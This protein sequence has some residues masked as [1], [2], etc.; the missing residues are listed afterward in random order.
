MSNIMFFILHEVGS[1][2]TSLQ[3]AIDL[4]TRGHM[5]SYVGLADSED[6][7]R[8]NGF[9]FTALFEQHFPKTSIPIL[10]KQ[11]TLLS[12]LSRLRSLRRTFATFNGF[13]DHLVAGGDGEFFAI[14]RRQR[15]D[16]ILFTGVPFVEWAV[17]MACAQ[18]IK[19]LYLRPTLSL[20]EGTGLPP[21]T[22]AVIPRQAKSLWQAISI[23]LAWRIYEF[24]NAVYFMGFSGL[25]RKLAAKYR[26]KDYRHETIYAKDF[27]VTLPEIIPFHPDFDFVAPRLPDQHYIGASICLERREVAFPW[28]RLEAERPL[29]YCALG[30][31]LW[32]SKS[33]YRQFFRAVL[34]AARAMPNWQWVI[35]IGEALNADEIGPIPENVIV[36]RNAPQIGL[37]KRAN[38]MI[39]H[40]GANTVKECIFLGVPMVIFPLGGDHRGIAARAVYHG[41]GMRGE[42]TKVDATRLMSLIDAATN[43]PFVRIQLRLMQSKFVEMDA[44]KVGVKLI[45]SLLPSGRGGH[46]DGR[47][48]QAQ[49]R[50]EKLVAPDSRSGQAGARPQLAD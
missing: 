3:L 15:P 26:I 19:G 48:E 50:D 9:E 31:Y 37:L 13:I 23:R 22:S 6:L 47:L 2:N 11:G 5:V 20:R 29:A 18:G 49:T 46:V 33:K 45:E 40:G 24:K 12:G 32:Y 36:V 16:L 8:A 43:N 34:G 7:I 38:V 27:A 30:T 4:R 35:A 17:L 42:F 25:T 14:T 44:A 10:G 21:V 41:L 1:L 39:T 28:E